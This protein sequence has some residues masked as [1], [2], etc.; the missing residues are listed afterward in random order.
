MPCAKS[1]ARRCTN[2]FGDV[3]RLIPALLATILTLAACSR[4]SGP[5]IE[6][7]D[8]WSPAAPP[9][10]S[11]VAVYAQIVCNRSDTLLRVSTSVASET[12]M[13]VTSEDKGMMRMRP[14]PRLE[15]KAGET[16]RFEPGGMHLMLTGLQQ[17][18]PPGTS[19]PMTFHFANA[20][21][22]AV[23]ATV[24]SAREVP[25]NH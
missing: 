24:Q 22:I 10:A 9:G 13:H 5:G 18:L 7:R 6:I 21:D 14:V 3:T 4:I 19:I 16:V 12:Q 2:E 15:L 25:S 23:T 20:G 17:P 11:V 8:A 1:S